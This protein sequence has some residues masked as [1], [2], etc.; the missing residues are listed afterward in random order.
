MLCAMRLFIGIG[1]P[2]GVSE[3]LTRA[4]RNLILSAENADARIRWTRPENMHVTL[5]FLGSV[6][7]SRLEEIQQALARLHASHLHIEFNGA[8]VFAHAS[9]LYAEV[10]HSSALLSLAEQVFQAME[11]C[12]FRREQR[13]YTPHVTLAR[14][15]GRIR[16]R[17]REA[18]DPAFRQQFE[19]REC[20]LYESFTR[21]EGSH[22]Q[23]LQTI[24][25]L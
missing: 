22:Y 2:P 3:L 11:H 9:T 4:A 7:P 20:S 8:G 23:V 18:T 21:P 10:K 17:S 24:P 16:L 6:E 15:K 19:A 1:V 25:L 14:S 13:P 12:G 5:S